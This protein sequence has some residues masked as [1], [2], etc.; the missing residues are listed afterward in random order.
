MRPNRDRE[1]IIK[2]TIRLGARDFYELIVVELTAF[3][4]LR[5]IELY[6]FQTRTC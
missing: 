4:L 3:I 6:P 1:R 2:L 5:I